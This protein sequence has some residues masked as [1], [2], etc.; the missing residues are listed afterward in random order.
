[1]S[2]RTREKLV[3]MGKTLRVCIPLRLNSAASTQMTHIHLVGHNNIGG[4]ELYEVE[5]MTAFHPSIAIEFDDRSL[6]NRFLAELPTAAFSFDYDGVA[7]VVVEE[8]DAKAHETVYTLGSGPINEQCA[9]YESLKRFFI[10]KGYIKIS[11]VVSQEENGAINTYVKVR[12]KWGPTFMQKMGA[13]LG[14]YRNQLVP[15]TCAETCKICLMDKKRA[16]PE[17]PEPFQVESQSRQE[18]DVSPT[19]PPKVKLPGQEVVQLVS[20]RQ[21]DIGNQLKRKA[22]DAAPITASMLTL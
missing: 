22:S 19:G 15:A 3:R 8:F 13:V 9:V 2:E 6:L 10:N 14:S 18:L 4:S 20:N 7:N 12:G 11:D 16:Q 1:M 21:Q 5:I 17:Y